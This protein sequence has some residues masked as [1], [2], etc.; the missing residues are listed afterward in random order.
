M[1]MQKL[2]HATLGETTAAPHT[3]TRAAA[4]WE[5]TV[6]VIAAPRSAFEAIAAHPRIAL[7]LAL[8]CAL[9]FLEALVFYHPE[10]TPAKLVLTFLVQSVPV[11][12]VFTITALALWA[13]LAALG[14]VTR[15]SR[16]AAVLAHTFFAYGLVRYLAGWVAMALCAQN[17]GAL[18]FANLGMF[19]DPENYP[20]HHVASSFDALKLGHWAFIAY[21]LSFVVERRDLALTATAVAAVWALQLCLTTA[22]KV[23]IAG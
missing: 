14:Q 2:A 19:V 1:S 8:A 15:L 7:P 20:L 13:S 23:F 3:G 6:G 21:G 11:L 18:D 10:R 16:M 9:R 22:F 12:V 4:W 17:A 5:T